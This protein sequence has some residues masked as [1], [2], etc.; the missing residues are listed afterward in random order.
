M[1]LSQKWFE[2]LEK[3]K[4]FNSQQQLH[5]QEVQALAHLAGMVIRTRQLKLKTRYDSPKKDDLK[6]H[7]LSVVFSSPG[8]LST[9]VNISQNSPIFH[10]G[11]VRSFWKIR[12]ESEQ[13]ESRV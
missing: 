7:Q 1:N 3:L 13:F 6:S 12:E 2:A 9:G 10:W 5:L 4:P 11:K 8:V